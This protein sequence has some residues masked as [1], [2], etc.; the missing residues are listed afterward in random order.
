MSLY[1]RWAQVRV[2]NVQTD[3]SEGLAVGDRMTLKALVHLGPVSPDSVD[4][5]AYTGPVSDLGAVTTGKAMTLNCT[6]NGTS[7][8][9]YTYEGVLPCDQSGR[10]GFEVRVL[11]KNKNL[12]SQFIPSLITWG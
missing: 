3:R 2:E 5:Q 7:P 1:Q 4:V 6:G 9:V 12:I 10:F 8:N 11:P